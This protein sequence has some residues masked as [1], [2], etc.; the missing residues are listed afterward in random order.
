MRPAERWSCTAARAAACGLPRALEKV[1][2]ALHLDH[3]KDME[4]HRLMLSMCAPRGIA[5]DGSYVWLDDW[6]RIERLGQYCI[7]DGLAERAVDYCLPVLSELEQ[8]V[9]CTTERMNDRGIAVDTK[10]LMRLMGLVRDATGYLNQRMVKLTNGQ[11]PAVTNPQKIVKWLLNYGIDVED[12]GIG[13]WIIQGI[14]EDESLPD[15]VREVLVIRRDGGKSS[16]AKFNALLRRLNNDARIRG[17]LLYA[18]AA[19]T[20]RWSS[21]GAQ[22]QNLPRGKVVKDPE[23]VIRAIFDTDATVHDIEREFGPPMVVASELVRPMFIA[24][25]GYWLARGDYS[26]IEARVNAW[27]AGETKILDAFREYD[28]IIGWD[29]KKNKPIR[30]GPDM[31]VVSAADIHGCHPSQIDDNQRQVGKVTILACIAE[32]QLVLTDQGLVPIER[33]TTSMRVWDGVEFVPHD[34]AVFK[35]EKDCI[36]YDGLIATEDH[37]VFVEGFAAAI[38]F[39]VAAQRGLRLQRT[40]VERAHWRDREGSER[41]VWDILNAGPRN[42]FTVSGRLVHNCGFQGGYRALMAMARIYALKITEDTA[43]EAVAKWREANQM[44]KSFWYELDRAAV[45][46]MRRDPGEIVQV[47][48]GIW[49]R[50]N[51]TCLV[52]HLP[53]GRHLVYWYPRLEEKVMPWTDE[54]GEPAKKWSVTY[55]AEDSQKKIWCRHTAYGG[56]WCENA[57]QATARDIMAY[58]LVQMDKKNM[59]P[60][61]TVHDEAVCQLS[62]AEYPTVQIAAEAVRKVMLTPPDWTFGLPIDSDASA[63]LRYAKG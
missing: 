57:V 63:G 48:S 34:G 11:V 31:Y 44:I 46:C 28:T 8:D 40:G 1:A 19:A 49:F 12:S 37:E 38:P 27:L 35:G 22:L 32:G 41:H 56:L 45:E 6:P 52:M 5:A 16:T 53:S 9:W 13:K 51:D 33:V 42:R 4:G 18:G 15:I 24:P 7:R 30:K 29:A 50:R 61:L 43:K 14:L 47:R 2:H 23:K 20:S 39:G 59:K 21:R 17:A 55:Y 10:L 26:Q 25:D 36:D 60:V 54:F 62:R 58:A 3:Q